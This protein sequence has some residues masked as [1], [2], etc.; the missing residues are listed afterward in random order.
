MAEYVALRGLVDAVVRDETVPDLTMRQIGV[1]VAV[2]ENTGKPFSVKHL[3]E[4]LR[5][6]KPAV[7]RS[8]DRLLKFEMAVRRQHPMDRRQVEVTLTKVGSDYLKSLTKA[9]EKTA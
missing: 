9:I 6:Q 2:A 8:V 4:Q 7:S 5:L 3:S 1:L